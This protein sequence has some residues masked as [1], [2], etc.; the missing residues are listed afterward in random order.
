M[1]IYPEI[2]DRQIDRLWADMAEHSE[3]EEHALMRACALTLIVL[4]D[5]SENPASVSETLAELMQTHPSRAIVIRLTSDE[6]EHLEADVRAYC[7]MPMGRRQQVCSEQIEIETSAD[8]FAD[9]PSA[10][11]PLIVPDLPVVLWCRSETAAALPAFA[12]L[13]DLAPRV[14]LDVAKFT[15]PMRA[16]EASA[17]RSGSVVATDV[18][19]TR[20]TRWRETVAHIFDNPLC[21][22][23]LGRLSRVTI[24]Y[25][26][27]SE[28]DIP[29]SALLLGGWL[30]NCLG[31]QWT[32]TAPSN[33]GATRLGFKTGDASAHL[34]FSYAGDKGSDNRLA[35]VVL[36][37]ED[38]D[39]ILVALDRDGDYLDIRV[40]TGEAEPS[41]TRV[42]FPAEDDAAVLNEELRIFTRDTQFE[43]A[44]NSAAKIAAFTA[45]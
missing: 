9:L 13:T 22:S 40:K 16:L 21:A 24:S 38:Q 39:G 26:G 29:V 32:G 41:G 35:R 44:L 3:G 1:P 31:W 11:L 30:V 10:L 7:W 6:G 14:I 42:L 19:W 4:T 27:G 8:S 28:S 37:T 17:Q 34:S 23:R 2:L 45:G 12:E 43:F 25:W 5:K 20:L 36:A 15:D 33:N 18:S